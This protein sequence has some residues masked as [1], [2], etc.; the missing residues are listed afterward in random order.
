MSIVDEEKNKLSSPVP[1]LVFDEAVIF[2]LL[3]IC[4]TFYYTYHTIS[5]VK[6][7]Q[8]LSNTVITETQTNAITS[9]DLSSYLDSVAQIICL[10][11]EGKLGSGSGVLWK[12][13]EGKY[14]IL[15]N[16]HVVSGAKK[17]VMS[18]DDVNNKNSGLFTVENSSH[19]FDESKDVAI[20]NIGESL[21]DKNKNI[22]DYNYNLFSLRK[23]PSNIPVGSP[24]SIIG[25]PSYTRRNTTMNIKD[26]G[27]I[28]TVYRATTNGTISGY[29]TSLLKP[30]GNLLNENY[31]ISAKTDIGNSGGIAL[32]KDENG[33]CVLGLPTWVTVGNYETQGLV[34]NIAN[35]V[36]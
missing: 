26:M 22:S 20:L 16:Y 17:C 34:Q 11:N 25:Y 6:K 18:I 4:A 14:N 13:K 9:S 31:F 19:S 12:N 15:T 7:E 32:G 21:S 29:D 1:W 27:N 5:S 28:S 35:I 30:A 23:C 24:V 33:L 2:L 10:S 3:L 8:S 36:P